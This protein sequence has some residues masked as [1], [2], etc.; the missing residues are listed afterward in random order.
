[1]RQIAIDIRKLQDFGIGTYIATLL[2]AAHQLNGEF[3]FT[4][5]H[6]PDEDTSAIPPDIKTLPEKA[7][8]YSPGEPFQLGST[9]R[10]NRFDLLHCPH[11]VTPYFAGAPVAVTIHDLIHLR[12][13]EQLPSYAAKLY[14]R[15]FIGK[16]IRK[17]RVIFT[18]SEFSKQD[19]L[20]SYDRNPDDIVVTH[21]VIDT[22]EFADLTQLEAP[23]ALPR[24]YVL[25][26]GNNKPHK[27]IPTALEA[28]ALFRKRMGADWHL[29]FAGGTFADEKAGAALLSRV[30]ELKI[31]DAV[32]F[33]GY[34]PRKQ[35]LAVLRSASIFIFPSRYE[36]FGLPPL[37]AMAAGV[38][39]VASRAASLPEVLGEAA[40]YADPG[41]VAMFSHQMETIATDNHL[42]EDLKV[43]G[44]SNCRRF[45]FDTF[46]ERL[47]AGYLK[48]LA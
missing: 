44:I 30:E 31:A 21:N 42:A 40:L 39:V 25:Y 20:Q 14:A 46:V 33:L 24:N 15:H 3:Q 22:R 5:L 23:A 27:D 43:A 47:K 37:E 19:I 45:S 4:A 29:C 12:L 1:M 2:R 8:L 48:G 35:L 13:P 9:V 17:A 38:P 10:S 41:D 11:Y 26:T 34:L 36:G 28:F 6:A 16:A 18:V 7:R 32:H